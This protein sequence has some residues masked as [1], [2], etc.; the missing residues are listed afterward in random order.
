MSCDLL[1]IELS[2]FDDAESWPPFDIDA[3]V[4]RVRL[5]SESQLLEYHRQREAKAAEAHRENE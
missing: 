1:D 5:A 4:D 3:T 2:P